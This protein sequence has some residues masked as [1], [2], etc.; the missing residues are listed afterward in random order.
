M[1]RTLPNIFKQGWASFLTQ[2]KDLN[3]NLEKKDYQFVFLKICGI[4]VTL[5]KISL[6]IEPHGPFSSLWR[7]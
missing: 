3:K 2:F 5:K 4:G 7:P 1:E 6:I